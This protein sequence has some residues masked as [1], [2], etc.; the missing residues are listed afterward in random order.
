VRVVGTDSDLLRDVIRYL[1]QRVM[2]LDTEGL[3]TAARGERGEPTAGGIDLHRG[4]ARP[5]C[6]LVF[7]QE[8]A[9]GGAARVLPKGTLGAGGGHEILRRRGVRDRFAVAI[10]RPL[11]HNPSYA[12]LPP[13]STGRSKRLSAA[14]AP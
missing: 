5:V 8:R 14:D 1:A 3:C 2:E 7:S 12:P 6:V 10:G 13:A 11:C 9:T 4:L